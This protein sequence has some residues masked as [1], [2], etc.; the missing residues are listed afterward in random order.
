VDVGLLT[1]DKLKILA[2]D[3]PKHRLGLEEEDYREIQDSVTAIIHNAWRVDFNLSLSSFEPLIAGVRNLIDLSLG[4]PKSRR[5]HIT[6]VSSISSLLGYKSSVPAKEEHTTDPRVCV[7]LG[8]GESKWVAEQLLA[9]VTQETGTRTTVVRV[10]QLAG[11]TRIGGWNP[12]EWVPAIVGISQ[13]LGYL[14]SRDEEVTWLPVDTA[15]SALLDMVH[16]DEQVLHLVH[17]RPVPWKDIFAPIADRLKLSLIPYDNWLEHLRKAADGD[18]GEPI[19]NG[20]HSA[21]THLREFF[22]NNVEAADV[23]LSTEKAVKVSRA[24]DNARPL[25]KDDAMKWLDFWARVGHIQL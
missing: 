1:S 4:S 20:G 9:R 19:A 24:L 11:D 14:P 23:R 6:F 12:K 10:G 8:Y 5:P 15:A 2:C 22:E 7:G 25:G 21:A 18:H 16:S 13:T 17:P 3:Y